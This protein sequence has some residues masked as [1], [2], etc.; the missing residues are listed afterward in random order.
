LILVAI[1]V[2]VWTPYR[3]SELGRAAYAI[4]SSEQAA[5]MSG[6]LTARAKLFAYVLAG[7]L[8]A[9]A[10]LM[11]TFITY[12]GEANAA[13]GKYTLNSTPQWWWR[14]LAIWRLG[15]RDRLDLWSLRVAGDQRSA[16]CV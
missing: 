10:G 2:F 13:L 5:Y 9:A 12:S 16:I 6:V 11:L 14:D 8:S 1:V 7:L 15:R 4:G 3:R